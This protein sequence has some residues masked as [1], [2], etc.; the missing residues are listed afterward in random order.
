MGAALLM[1]G[2]TSIQRVASRVG[3]SSGSKFAIAFKKQ[4]GVRPKHFLS[5]ITDS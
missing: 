5:Y 4:Y 1:T 2:E 3:Y